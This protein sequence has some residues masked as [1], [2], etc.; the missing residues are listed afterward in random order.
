MLSALLGYFIV[1]LSDDGWRWIMIIASVPVLLLL[2]WR[3][4]LF[5]S[6]RWLEMTGRTQE[7]GQTCSA[8]ESEVER[9][10]GQPLPQ[11]VASRKAASAVAAEQGVWGKLAALFSP[12]YRGTTALIWLLWI[13]VLFCY[14]AFLVWIPSLL[15]AKGFTITKSFSFTILIYLAQIPAT[16]PP[17][18][19][20]T[21]SAASTRSWRTCWCPA[22]RRW[23]WPWPR[24]KRRSSR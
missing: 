20:T 12:A 21:A 14:Y 2:W 5:E 11:P 22:W 18:I 3:K 24:T 16:T 7:A 23:G 9:H 15:V 4:S 10:L 13:T 1:P 17:P 19:S 8:I 6:P